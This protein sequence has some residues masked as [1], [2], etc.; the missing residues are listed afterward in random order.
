MVK[1]FP[2]GHDVNA[3]IDKAFERMKWFPLAPSTLAGTTSRIAQD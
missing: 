1:K 3:Y 2:Y